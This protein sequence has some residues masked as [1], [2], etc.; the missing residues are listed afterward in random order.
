MFLAD[1]RG[2]GYSAEIEGPYVIEEY[3]DDIIFAL[4]EAG[5]ARTHFWGTHTGAAI[6]LVL[7]LRY[8]ERIS[9]LV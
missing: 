2:H 9:S 3:A 7:A 8:P 6:G 1:L 5:I 4:D